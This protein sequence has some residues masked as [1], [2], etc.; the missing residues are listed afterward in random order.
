[1]TFAVTVA[2]PGITCA[3]S[4]E[5]TP[6]QK[7]IEEAVTNRLGYRDGSQDYFLYYLLLFNSFNQKDF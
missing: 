1:L 6:V 5:K 3:A 2:S 4:V 7:R